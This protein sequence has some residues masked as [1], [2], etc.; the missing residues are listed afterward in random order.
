MQATSRSSRP[1]EA[2]PQEPPHGAATL[3]CRSPS[4]AAPHVLY[5]RPS[6]CALPAQGSLQKGWSV[7]I[8]RLRGKRLQARSGSRWVKN[9][10]ESVFGL[11]TPTCP[12]CGGFNVIPVGGYVPARCQHCGAAMLSACPQHGE[13]ECGESCPSRPCASCSQ[14]GPIPPFIDPKAWREER[15]CRG[16][17]RMLPCCTG[18]QK[19][20]DPARRGPPVVNNGSAWHATCLENQHEHG[21][22]SAEIL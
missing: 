6:L 9:T 20:L 11:T 21:L 16:C 5:W 2:P 12:S 13:A 1:N 18:C 8:N 3:R 19:P 4:S 15:L 7:T 17:A 14:T 22:T 10:V